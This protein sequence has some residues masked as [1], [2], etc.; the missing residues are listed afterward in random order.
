MSACMLM[1]VASVGVISTTAA[2]VESAEV[3]A[4]VIISGDYKYVLL[5]DGTIEFC[6]SAY[7]ADAKN[8]NIIKYEIPAQI[9]GYTVTTISKHAFSQW[10]YLEEIIIPDTVIVIGDSAFS[11][12]EKLKE[13]NIPDNVTYLGACSFYR[14][15]SL[16]SIEIPDGVTEIKEATFNYCYKL[17]KVR[18]PENLKKIGEDAF[19]LCY[20]L[21]EVTLPDSLET[22][23]DHAFLGCDSIE[24]IV[25]PNN[26]TR[27][28]SAFWGCSSLKS[29]VIPDSVTTIGNTL[30]AYCPNLTDVTL[31]KNITIIPNG[32][33]YDCESLKNITIPEGVTTVEEEAF[34]GC[35]ELKSI[36][37][38]ESVTKIGKYA[39][40]CYDLDG[41]Q[42]VGYVKD[43]CVYGYK[44]TVAEVYADTNSLAFH[45][46][47]YIG[48]DD[49]YFMDEN[50]KPEINKITDGEIF[51]KVQ[52]QI[53][54][55]VLVSI[56]DIKFESE[57]D[58]TVIFPLLASL[59]RLYYVESDG[60]LNVVSDNSND[61]HLKLQSNNGGVFALTVL[62]ND[63]NNDGEMNVIDATYLQMY[64][65]GYGISIDLICADVNRDGKI[66]VSDVTKLQLILAG[67]E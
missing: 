32:A 25:I 67:A 19:G 41:R 20:V 44:Y 60:T 24:E 17:E 37:I 51:E 22:M 27:I 29:L 4:D 45:N 12:C 8:K 54:D 52:S 33:F 55:E 11:R 31:S 30:C 15:V 28:G 23:E 58:V 7:A 5:D 66:D 2:E 34:M 13:L 26:V 9:D 16:T 39:F 21:K 62:K 49:I 46:L 59:T 38:P 57:K 43:F 35:V 6:G 64:L 18:L 48:M 10:K 36:K 53:D 14:C 50:I 1:S 61:S 65:A 42:G 3:S 47:G 40:G 56:Y 63:I